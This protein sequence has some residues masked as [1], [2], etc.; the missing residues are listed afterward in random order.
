MEGANKQRQILFVFLSLDMV[1]WNSASGGFAYIWQSKWVGIIAINT[2]RT[3]LHFL[4]D[5]PVVVASL[6]LLVP[7]DKKKVYFA[8]YVRYKTI[9]PLNLKS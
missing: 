7:N 6:D 1:T 4:I 3:Q 2:E 5:V 9:L 8:A